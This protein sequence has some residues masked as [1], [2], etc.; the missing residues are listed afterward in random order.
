MY[1]SVFLLSVLFLTACLPKTLPTIGRTH[2]DVPMTMLLEPTEDCWRFTERVYF[3]APFATGMGFDAEQ[4]LAGDV[5]IGRKT[6]G[7][8]AA[9]HVTLTFDGEYYIIKHGY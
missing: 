2:G 3:E 4:C 1:K 7:E 8:L 9:M 6:V 5:K